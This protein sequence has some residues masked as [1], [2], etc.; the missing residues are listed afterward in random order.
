MSIKHQKGFTLIEVLVASVILSSVFFAILK[1]ISNNTHQITNLEH[2][3]T[4]DSVFLSSK[5]CIKSFWYTVLSGTTLTQS[6]NFGVDNMNCATGSYDTNLSFTGISFKRKNDIETSVT[7]FW[8]YFRVENNT[9]SLKIY[10]TISDGIEKKD[11]DFL[12]GQ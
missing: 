12:I 8:S 5:A 10:S 4:M 3:K 11:Y 6:L 7:T 9:G 2:S 1:L